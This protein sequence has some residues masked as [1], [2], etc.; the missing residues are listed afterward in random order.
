MVGGEKDKKRS[1]FMKENWLLQ[2]SIKYTFELTGS[3]GKEFIDGFDSR[4]NVKL[5]PEEM[6]FLLNNI[7][8]N[9]LCEI[10]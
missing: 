9:S 10:A 6:V 3:Q 8:V 7:Y 5:L 4:E 2:K 1:G